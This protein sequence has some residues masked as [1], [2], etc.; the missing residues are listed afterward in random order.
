MTDPCPI[1][2]MSAYVILK[3]SGGYHVYQLF[4]KPVPKT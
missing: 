2:E 4:R 3:K 1:T